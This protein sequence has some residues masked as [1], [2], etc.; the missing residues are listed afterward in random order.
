MVLYE[1]CFAQGISQGNTRLIA[2]F[3]FDPAALGARRGD[4][5]RA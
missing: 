5:C 4:V 3:Y 2:A 1:E